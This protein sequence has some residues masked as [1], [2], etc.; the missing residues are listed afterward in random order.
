MSIWGPGPFENDDAADWFADLMERPGLTLIGEALDEVVD[1]T[2][3]GYIDVGSGCEAI[4]AAAALGELLLPAPDDP[5]VEDDGAV[6]LR[7]EWEA[8]APLVKQRLLR[9]AETALE[10]VLNDEEH[11]EVRQI[12]EEFGEFFAEWT[13][14]LKNLQNRLRAAVLPTP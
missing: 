9:Q 1:P 7:A 8:E 11:S 2:H 5:E 3:A 4:A 14:I 13:E 12:V 6:A 10:L